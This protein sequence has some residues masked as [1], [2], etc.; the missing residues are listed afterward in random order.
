[1]KIKTIPALL[2]SITA[3]IISIYSL[4]KKSPKFYD[5]EGNT[6]PTEIVHLHVKGQFTHL[7][8]ADS[9]KVAKYFY[10]NK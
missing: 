8:P 6:I 1:M 10:V 3:L 7:S 9:I 5:S 2:F 4:Y